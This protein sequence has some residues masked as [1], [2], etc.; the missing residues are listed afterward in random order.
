MIQ[1]DINTLCSRVEVVQLERCMENLSSALARR[2]T[3]WWEKLKC[4]HD[5][6]RIHRSPFSPSEMGAREVASAG[7]CSRLRAAAKRTD[8]RTIENI[9]EIQGKMARRTAE[10]GEISARIPKA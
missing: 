9:N 8:I 6:I 1:T 7:G 5:M 3:R 4:C 10:R 2:Y